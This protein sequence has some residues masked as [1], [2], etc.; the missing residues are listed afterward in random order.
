MLKYT[1]QSAGQKVKLNTNDTKAVC[2]CQAAPKL[3][4]DQ[5]YFISAKNVSLHGAGNIT[6]LLMLKSTLTGRKVKL[7]T[8][9]MKAN[10][11]FQVASETKGKP[12]LT[13]LILN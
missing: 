1:R 5:I 3:K 4:A 2:T 11:T 13:S 12:K 6:F 10:C 7:H 9:I 8:N